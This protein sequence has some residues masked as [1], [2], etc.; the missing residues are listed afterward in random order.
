MHSLERH[1]WVERRCNYFTRE[2]LYREVNPKSSENA[3]SERQM[4]IFGIAIKSPNAPLI[5]LSIVGS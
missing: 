3:G 1:L 4:P 2:F 5:E